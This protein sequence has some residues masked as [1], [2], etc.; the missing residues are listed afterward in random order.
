MT[1]NNKGKNNYNKVRNL[2]Q[3]CNLDKGLNL[4]DEKDACDRCMEKLGEDYKVYNNDI[5][6]CKSCS[7]LTDQWLNS[8]FREKAFNS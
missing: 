1:N 7:I 2:D 4:V 8:D 6:R 3:I 5:Y